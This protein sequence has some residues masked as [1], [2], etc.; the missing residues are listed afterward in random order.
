MN[1]TCGQPT[2]HGSA[3]R[4]KV[5]FEDIKC[6]CHRGETVGQCSICLEVIKSAETMGLACYHNFHASCIHKWLKTNREWKD[7]PICRAIVKDRK[8]LTWIE[9]YEQ[10]E[11]DGDW[12]PEKEVTVPRRR[13]RRSRRRVRSPEHSFREVVTSFYSRLTSY[14]S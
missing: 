5:P 8:T 7:C 4:K 11:E 6:Y 13:R 9:E 12:L 3:C 14:L 1:F 10:K 2:K